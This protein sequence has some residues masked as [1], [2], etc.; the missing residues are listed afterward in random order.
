MTIPKPAHSCWARSVGT[1]GPPTATSAGQ[2]VPLSPVD[3][4]FIGYRDPNNPNPATN[5][6]VPLDSRFVPWDPGFLPGNQSTDNISNPYVNY[7]TFIDSRPAGRRCPTRLRPSRPVQTLDQWGVSANVDWSINENNSLKWISSYRRYDSS[8]AQDVDGSPLASQQ[9]LQTLDHLA[10][11]QELRWNGQAFG[12]LLDFT[13]GGFYYKQEGT[14]EAR[15]DLPYAGLDF[16]HGPDQTP[17]HSTAAFLHTEWH[18]TDALT[19]IGGV[20]WTEDF[21]NYIYQRRNVDLTL[22]QPCAPGFPF[23]PPIGGPQPP[24]CLLAG[25]FNVAPA[26]PYKDDRID[27]RV[28]AQYSFTENFMG[29]L[30]VPPATR[31][32]A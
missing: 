21:K 11:S 9:L 3:P 14:L 23:G 10:W 28:G 13:L 18:L 22:P 2:P 5:V 25:L 32:A 30:S 24:N 26:D 1:Q 27:W 8:W 12:D 29:Y 7:A 16:I 15:V 31:V 17:A 4:R 20:R 19:L 6:L